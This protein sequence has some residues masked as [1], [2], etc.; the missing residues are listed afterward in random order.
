MLKEN[1]VRNTTLR[2]ITV[3]EMAMA[4]VTD[5]DVQD[6]LG[7]G[8]YCGDYSMCDIHDNLIAGVR[9][10]PES[11]DTMRQGVAIVSH[12]WAHVDVEDNAIV[13]TPR[14]VGAF[15]NAR[16]TSE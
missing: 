10:D 2:G 7:I 13:R 6:V 15:A 1:S 9:S 14:G 12:Y 5:N 11:S 8:I 16:V 3:T 4:S